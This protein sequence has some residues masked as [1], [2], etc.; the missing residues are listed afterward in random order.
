MKQGKKVK[1]KGKGKQKIK[2]SDIKQ[3]AEM[4]FAYGIIIIM[5]FILYGQTMWYNYA[6]DDSIVIKKN[7][8]TKQGVAGIDDI[9]SNDT[10]VGFFGK[11]KNLVAGGRYRPLSVVTFAIEYQMFGLRPGFSHFVNI[12]LYALIG[13]ILFKILSYLLAKF[14]AIKWYFSIPFVT[15]LLFMAHPVHTEVVA[16]I[17]GRDEIMTLLGSLIALWYSLK[18]LDNKQIKYLVY[19]FIAFFLAFL[20]K[21]NTITFLAII[22]LAIYFFTDHKLKDNLITFIPLAVATIIFLAIRQAILGNF[23]APVAKELMNNPFLNATE[24]EKFATI[25]Y[26]LWMYLKLLFVPHPLTYD[27]Y[28]K[29]IPIIGWGDIRAWGS[30]LIY[31]ALGIYAIFG[32]IKKSL[33]SFGIIFYIATLSVV[34]NLVFPVGTFMNERFIFISSVGF[35]LIIAWLLVEKLPLLIKNQKSFTNILTGILVT[36][37]LLYSVKSI[38]R[39]RAWADDYTL[40]TTDAYTSTKSAKGNA[41]VAALYREQAEAAKLPAEKEKYWKLAIKHFS[42]SVEVYP[43][44]F[45]VH[46]DLAVSHFKHN[47]NMVEAEKH[48]ISAFK[49]N[50]T[51]PKVMQFSNAIYNELKKPKTKLGFFQKIN[52]LKPDNYQ[53]LYTIG[54]IYGKDL[55][56]LPRAI[57]YFE[58]AI[59]KNPQGIEAIKDLGVAY[60]FMK[61]Y[62]K[63]IEMSKKAISI[64]PKDAQI[65]VNIGVNYRNMGNEAKAKEY[66]A[67]AAEWDPKYKQLK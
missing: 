29:Q 51:N 11:K 57:E 61:D 55:Q 14:K 48:L 40:F 19:S 23:S 37:M 32:L 56:N 59:K 20:S 35:C 36:I 26:T 27:Y 3:K 53:V 41:A 52:D 12:I 39:N 6:L 63:S 15:T 8:F 7:E 54:S 65:Y 62:N 25:F 4:R 47:Q 28:P 24:G 22:P 38:S 21:E 45:D 64:D 66:F 2:P 67:K 16:N 30:L 9:L 17:K 43:N 58:K 33:L 42:R 18:Y 13:I 10:F 60:G 34:S 31:I 49:I 50:S 1:V 46:L 44:Y 5:A